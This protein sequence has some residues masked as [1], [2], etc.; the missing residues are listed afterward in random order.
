MATVFSRYDNTSPVT[1]ERLITQNFD[2]TR[3]GVFIRFEGNTKPTGFRGEGRSNVWHFEALFDET[4]HDDYIA[5]KNMFNNANSAADARIRV[6]MTDD[7]PNGSP[8]E[9]NQVVEIHGW[10]VAREPGGV[11]RM[12]FDAQEVEG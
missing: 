5:L 11:I 7:V 1:V 3:E 4:T 8:A 10:S 9:K 6:D 2:R 12:T